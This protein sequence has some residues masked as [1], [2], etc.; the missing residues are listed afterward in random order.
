MKKST[1]KANKEN[2]YKNMADNRHSFEEEMLSAKFADSQENMYGFGEEEFSGF[3]NRKEMILDSLQRYWENCKVMMMSS[4]N[5][6]RSPVT[7]VVMIFLIATYILLGWAGSVDFQFYNVD[8]V[9]QITTNLDIIINA[10]LG[11][12]FGPVTCAIGVALCTTVRMI[13][14][15][16]R[17][18]SIYFICATVAGFLHGWI[19][20]RHKSMWFGTRFRGFFTDLL[21]KVFLTRFIVSA[22]INV[23]LMAVLYAVMYGIPINNYLMLYSKSG[24]PLTSVYEFFSVFIISMLFEILIVYL[25]LVVITFIIS[26]AFP[27]QLAEP[28]LIVD[29]TG[30][31]ID[32]SDDYQ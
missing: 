26:K 22:F 10:I 23:I 1:D 11:Y 2:K 28:E 24:V 13:V 16:S 3:K 12:F 7:I 19:L 15:I 25:A 32:P 5:H 27:S 8:V 31:I 20:Y 4:L 14:K 29:E 17:F 30:A 9:Q 18:Y 6:M 21:S